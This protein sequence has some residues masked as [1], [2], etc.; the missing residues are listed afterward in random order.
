MKEFNF[1]S[2]PATSLVR[3]ITS[4]SL[5]HNNTLG[6]RGQTR[7]PGSLE[8]CPWFFLSASR[9]N[10]LSNLAVEENLPLV[11]HSETLDQS[12][13]SPEPHVF[14]LNRT[15]LIIGEAENFNF[16]FYPFWLTFRSQTAFIFYNWPLQ[17]DG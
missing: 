1:G 5:L 16:R 10:L 13:Q 3:L 9:C 8:I 7:L 11:F 14:S 15:K 6:S 17:S 4:Y 12:E 2:N